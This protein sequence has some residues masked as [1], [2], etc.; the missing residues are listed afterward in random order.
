[1][2][3]KQLRNSILQ[4][5]IQGKLVPQDP[6]DEPAWVLLEK[7]R[8]EKAKQS[9]A[10]KG[11]KT[12]ISTSTEVDT[13]FDI[14]SSWAWTTLGEIGKWQAGATPNRA[15][16]SY[17]GGD[18][19]W[20]KTGDLNDGIIDNIPENIT[21]KALKETSV[22]LNPEGSVLIAMYGATI[23]KIGILK[24]PA[25]TNQACCACTEYTGVEQKYL[26]YF[27]LSH[28]DEFIRL[29][30]GGAQPNISK[31]K[32]VAT[33]F[34]LPPLA[35]QRRIVEKI[36]EVMPLVNRYEE[37]QMEL[38][39][40]NGQIKDLLKKS[41]LQ[42]AIQGRLVEQDEHDEPAE[43][44]LQRIRQQKQSDKS[45]K[46]KKSKNKTATDFTPPFQIP[47]SWI[48]TTIGEIGEAELG[49]TLDN[50]RNKGELKPY[51]CALNV[52]WHGF[53][54]ANIKQIKIEENEKERYL[55]KQG[56]LLICE[57]GDV[58]RCAIWKGE[59]EIYYQN[60]LHRVRFHCGVSTKFYEYVLSL[61]KSLG[62]IDDRSKGVTIK[63][64]T[65]GVLKA[66]P[67]P[68]P[69]LAEQRRIVEKIE[70]AFSVLDGIEKALN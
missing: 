20:L 4:W 32:I 51:L 23:G 67:V 17:Y 25:T 13:P 65:S 29:G 2:N 11:K 24:F 5:A 46:N 15:N 27:L 42:E 53:N 47:S 36:E 62:V 43:V 6:N 37:C 28:R 18:I 9:K 14:P 52:Q 38:D 64:F 26:F 3:G 59:D 10:R 61:F 54:L 33:L 1:M 70:E 50:E 55:L 34:P 16:S 41:I 40:L 12:K 39:E 30:G 56:D 7:I 35:E 68:L 44:L 69:P 19:P 21:Q 45:N 63:H 57:G 60:A 49:K 66:L 48:W 31:E 22:K 58:G 8:A